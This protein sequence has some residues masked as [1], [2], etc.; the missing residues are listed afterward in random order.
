MSMFRRLRTAPLVVTL[1]LLGAWLG[2]TLE[3]V[4]VS[5]TAGLRAELTGSIHAYMVP[6]GIV[7]G[8]AVVAVAA[9]GA[10]VYRSLGRRLRASRSRLLTVLAS[11]ATVESS[12]RAGRR[13]SAPRLAQLWFLVLATQLGIYVVQ[14]RFEA[15]RVGVDRPWLSAVSG[16]HWASPLIHAA[17]ALLVCGA[18]LVALRVIGRR[19]RVVERSE[20]L[21]AAIVARLLGR[22]D[23]W[24]LPRS[25]VLRLRLRGTHLWSRPPP[26]AS[27]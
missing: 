16:A 20:R 17:T 8:L 22:P 27:A 15:L 14:E 2:H 21:L 10:H 4:R 26:L 25:A 6:A 13:W 12:P 11:H 3:Y 9:L 7:L 1:A 23:T 5:G 19:R 18:A 24:P